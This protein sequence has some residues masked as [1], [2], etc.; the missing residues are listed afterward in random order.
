MKR[1]LAFCNAETGELIYETY[2]WDG[3]VE[4]VFKIKDNQRIPGKVVD[5]D[6]KWSDTSSFPVSAVMYV[7]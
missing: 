5:A 7:R 3:S 4:D 6:N 1:H 2:T